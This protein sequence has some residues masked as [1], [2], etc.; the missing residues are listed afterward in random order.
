MSKKIKI[1]FT[2]AIALN[3]VMAV[4]NACVGAWMAASYAA[5]VA[6]FTWLLYRQAK[7]INEL[8]E[9][10]KRLRADNAHWKYR[11]EHPEYDKI[12]TS[13]EKDGCWLENYYNSIVAPEGFFVGDDAWLW[14]KLEASDQNHAPQHNS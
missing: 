10:N 6:V 12:L 13:I 1:A 2:I 8:V 4:A 11:H 3:G 14:G 9:E 7:L 5:V